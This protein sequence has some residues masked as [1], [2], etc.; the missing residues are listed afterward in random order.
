MNRSKSHHGGEYLL[1]IYFF[2][3]IFFIKRALHLSIDPFTLLLILKTHLIPINLYP[4]G[5][6][7]NSHILFLAIELMS[8]LMT[9]IHFSDAGEVMTSL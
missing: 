2:F 5:R 6:S 3:Y 9:T 1:V 7:I 4:S 8:P